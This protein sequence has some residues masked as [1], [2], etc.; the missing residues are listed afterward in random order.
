MERYNNSIVLQFDSQTTGNGGANIAVTVR[1][2]VTKVKSILYSDDQGTEMDNP[3]YSGPMG[4]Y[5]FYIDDGR[6]DIV[7]NEGNP[8]SYTIED[9][10]I[11]QQAALEVYA[12]EAV[13][14]VQGQATYAITNTLTTSAVVIVNGTVQQFTDSAYSINVIDNE[15]TFSEPPRITDII[16]VWTTP[17]AITPTPVDAK[18]VIVYDTVNEALNDPAL[19]EGSV[20][21][22]KQTA[23]SDPKLTKWDVVATSSVTPNLFNIRQSAVK[24]PLSISL[25]GGEDW[26]FNL[27]YG[28]MEQIAHRGYLLTAPENTV[29]AFSNSLDRGADSIEIDIQ[30]SADGTIWCYHDPN[31]DTD[32]N[33]TGTISGSTDA[34]LETATLNVANG[35]RYDGIGLSR[36]EDVLSV[37]RERGVKIYPEMKFS[38]WTDQ[39]IDIL[40]SLLGSYNYLNAN[41][42]IQAVDTALLEYARAQ[43]PDVLLAA[44]Q[45]GDFTFAQ[46]R[47]DLMA[48]LG[49]GAI[50]WDHNNLLAE[51]ELFFPYCFDRGV[52]IVAFTVRD[53]ALA[54]ELKSLGCNGIIIDT[55]MGDNL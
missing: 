46:P 36:F 1:D 8:G 54:Q 34:Y 20:V 14:P 9:E 12:K 28:P 22:I 37:A 29:L 33:L 24:P 5:F 21:D 43:N 26:V 39:N 51:P 35:T 41:C 42:M 13:T 47:I 18:E 55:Y 53:V 3:T 7:I 50:V 40:L 15:I 17:L 45:Q 11:F 23:T 27:S 48:Q 4:N 38:G 32:T 31:L 19:E 2:T 44:D 49:N 10:A 6:Y 30:P 16:E 25:R 52:R